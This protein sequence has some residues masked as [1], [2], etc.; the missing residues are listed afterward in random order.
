MVRRMEEQQC[1]CLPK[2][3]SAQHDSANDQRSKVA[4]RE[5]LV[6]LSPLENRFRPATC[7]PT[8][9]RSGCSLTHR[10]CAKS[11]WPP[12]LRHNQASKQPLSIEGGEQR[13]RR[14]IA[15]WANSH[16]LFGVTRRN[17]AT[18]PSGERIIT[19]SR[20]ANRIRLGS[21]TSVGASKYPHPHDPVRQA[22]SIA[23]LGSP[24]LIVGKVGNRTV[25]W[26]LIEPVIVR[27]ITLSTSSS[28]ATRYQASRANS[29][30][31]PR[32]NKTPFNLGPR[33]HYRY[34][35]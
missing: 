4:H 14:S 22:Q 17:F 12:S 11:N 24:R 35:K 21:S 30:R 31:C 20:N 18:S 27:R 25:E 5:T 23:G 29:S 15:I 2:K 33:R 13:L 6:E 26:N 1:T 34:I 32:N 3:A 16:T 28:L 19:F 7:W 10:D 9:D 8:T